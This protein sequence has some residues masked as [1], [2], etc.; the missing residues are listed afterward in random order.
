MSLQ[1]NIKEFDKEIAVQQLCKCNLG[2]TSFFGWVIIG[3]F[4]NVSAFGSSKGEN[5]PL[6]VCSFCS[7]NC[8]E[9]K[10]LVL[11]TFGKMQD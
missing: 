6:R 1:I 5:K 11:H 4:G 10:E 7:K 9:Q 3:D 8:I 2:K